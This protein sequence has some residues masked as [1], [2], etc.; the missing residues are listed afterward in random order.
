MKRLLLLF[1][2][3]VFFFS[4]EE[5][6]SN[7][8]CQLIGVWNVDYEVFPEGIDG[9]DYEVISCWCGYVSDICTELYTYNDI[10][11]CQTLEFQE[12]NS[13]IAIE[14]SNSSNQLNTIESEE[15][16]S[17]SSNGCA[18]NDLITVN[19]EG[20]LTDLQITIVSI[21]ANNL[22]LYVDASVYEYGVGYYIYLSQ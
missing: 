18:E 12:N 5:E 3:L 4:C 21:S 15:S 1:I 8:S 22:T 19:G 6:E 17:W 14:Y 10:E 2:P 20:G 16:F 7:E 11:Y 13:L 9:E